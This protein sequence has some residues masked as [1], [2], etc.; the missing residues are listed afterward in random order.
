MKDIL[1]AFTAAMTTLKERANA[2]LAPLGPIDQFEGAREVAYALS[3][4]NYAKDEVERLLGRVNE[5]SEKYSAEVTAEAA[6]L[7]DTKVNEMV[8]AGELVK[9]GDVEVAVGLAEKNGKDAAALEFASEKLELETIAAR[10]KTLGDTHGAEVAGLVSDDLLKGE[11]ATFDAFN[12]ELG[13]RA[14]V[15]AEI[16]VTAKDAAK[17][18]AFDDMACGISFGEGGAEAFDKR[19][20]VVKALVPKNGKR[21]TVTASARTNPGQVPPVTTGDRKPEK[22]GGGPKKPERKYA[23]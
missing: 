9:K 16:G 14:T 2:S 23:F 5:I 10:R 13:R 21:E 8:A 4:L 7:V 18:D 11:P 3:T 22:E 6:T 17:K 1:A 20:S 15:L 12:A 19:V